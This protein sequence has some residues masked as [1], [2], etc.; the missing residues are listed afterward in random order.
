VFNGLPGQTN[1]I[2]ASTDLVTWT[3]LG[4][5][6]FPSTDPF[7]PFIDIQDAAS[8]NLARRYFPAFSLP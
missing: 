8:T 7:C 6:V 1:I 3:A 5:N 2:E 4:T